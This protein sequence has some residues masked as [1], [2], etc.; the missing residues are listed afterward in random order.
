MGLTC[1]QIASYYCLKIS[2]LN[3]AAFDNNCQL[4][5][6]CFVCYK[7]NSWGVH[8]SKKKRGPFYK[9]ENSQTEQK[10]D[11][12]FIST[13]VEI[14]LY[15]RSEY[16]FRVSRSQWKLNRYHGTGTEAQSFMSTY[17]GMAVIAKL[18]NASAISKQV[19]SSRM[20]T[21]RL[22][23]VRGEGVLW[24]GP[25]GRGGCGDQVR[26]GGGEL[27]LGGGGV[28]LGPRGR[29]V[30]DHSENWTDIMGTGT[31]GPIIYVGHIVVWQSLQKL[32]NASAIS[33]QVHSSRMC[34]VR[35]HT[36]HGGCVTRVLGEGDIVTRS[37]GGGVGGCC[38]QVP[39]GRGCC[40]QVPRGGGGVVTR[41]RGGEL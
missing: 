29:G 31:G 25:Q 3:S 20:R 21:V 4:C 15:F 9:P 14:N 6:Y 26:G 24:P 10:L 12:N 28:V 2:L 35:L 8:S 17:C 41:S 27:W 7:C 11:L 40:G 18:P 19:H 16:N 37:R 23:T 36:V 32:P 1:Y 33:K 38:D 30:L 39:G 13:K 34:T 22:R 5:Y